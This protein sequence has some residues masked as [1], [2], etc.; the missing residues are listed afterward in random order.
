M[1]NSNGNDNNYDARRRRA[2]HN[3][4]R[5]NGPRVQAENS[6]NRMSGWLKLLA[7]LGILGFTGFFAIAITAIIVYRGYADDLVA[8]DELAINKPSYGARVLDRNG[9]LLYEY[10]DDQAGLRRPIKIEDVAPAFL[11]A[12]I[13][14]EDDSFFSNPGVNIKGLARAAWENL[15]PF[16]DTPGA[17]Q[18]SGGSSITQQLV[19]NVY[20]GQEEVAESEREGPKIQAVIDDFQAKLHAQLSDLKILSLEEDD[21]GL[22]LE[23][24][25]LAA[26]PASAKAASLSLQLLEARNAKQAELRT[27]LDRVSEKRQSRSISRKIKETAYALQLTERYEKERILEWYINQIS[28]GG[29]Y[30]GIEAAAQGYFSKS[31]KDLTLAEA[32]ML[33]GIPQSPAAYDP[34]NNPE[35][36]TARRNQILDILLDKGD[37]RIGKDRHYIVNQ[38]EAVAARDIPIEIAVK[39]FPI[40]AP[41]FVLQYVQPQLVEM[42]GRDA[43]YRDGLVVTTTLDIDLQHRTGEIM[44]KWIREFENISASRNG[45]MMI[46]DPKTGEVLTMIGSRDYFREDIEGKNNNATA[47][48]SPGSSFKPFAY[49][50]AFQDL[51]WGPG[52]MIL[53]SPI[54]YKDGRGNEFTPANPSKNFSG[55]VTIR[56]ALGNS[57]NIPANKTAAAVGADKIVNL[58]RKLGFMNTFRLQEDGGCS[59][60]AGY[61]PAIATGGV[62]VTLEEMMFGY[63]VLAN[64]G[65]MK[66]QATLKPEFRRATERKID[67]IAVLKVTDAQG[68]TR[69]DVEERRKSERVVKEEYTYLISN[70]LSDSSS[71]CATFGCGGISVP[72]R[73][74]G[75]KTGT[76]EPYDPKGPNAGKIGET[77]AFGYTPDVVVGIW[78]GNSKNQPIVN[79]FSTS[80]SFR[81][82]RDTIQQAYYD[83]RTSPA[84]TRPA[85]LVD[86]TLCV[87]SGLKPTPFCGKTTKD[88][89]VKDSLPTKEDDWWQ[90]VRV[91]IRN[92]LIAGPTTPLQFVQEQVMLVLP[93]ELLKTEDDKKRAQEWADA[94]KLPLAPTDA[95]PLGGGGGL[96]G[97]PG[98]NANDPPALIFSPSAGQR[99][100]GVVIV[101]GRAFS[102]NFESYTLEVGSGASPTSWQMVN[103][104]RIPSQGGP[105]GAFNTVNLTPGVYTIRLTVNDRQR[106]AI[107]STV[108]VNVGDVPATPT[109]PSGAA[110]LRP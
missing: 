51:G 59:Q 52:T 30:N 102:P 76:S 11:A 12:T 56:H 31:A 84:F 61:G 43:L 47:C 34:V 33:A 49:L 68:R 75:V 109:P 22:T 14:T 48:N 85:G 24:Q 29:V 96:P 70:V 81:A 108:T 5:R 19:K 16:A 72:G 13:A 23:L 3:Q 45:S 104:Q 50:T 25:R 20:I 53:D 80:I 8:P 94:L 91:D 77:W 57:L 35:A 18:G 21:Q 63:S 58:A 95:S 17:L 100:E 55:P 67:P 89:F 32:A 1:A 92:N 99:V 90:R 74:A 107:T 66:G 9:K 42:L 101:N 71:Q 87:P 105:L 60:G 78:A 65:L 36:A 93:P 64:G 37:I 98:G 2:R 86:E 88:L 10:V 44:E 97:T 110:P 6:G 79:I 4:R 39:R 83:G 69:F 7:A 15:S 106:G 54:T 28:Y 73:S 103:Q 41:H 82:M 62:D 40:E 38:E 46:M 26:I 27:L